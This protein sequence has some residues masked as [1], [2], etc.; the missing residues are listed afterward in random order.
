ML[1]LARTSAS[2]V[3]LEL[4][5]IT[6]DRLLK[7]SAVEV[8]RSPVAHGNRLEPLGDHFTVT[9]DPADGRLHLS[10]DTTTVKRIGEGMAAG[11]L[12][13]E[14]PVGMHAGA[15]MAGGE[16]TLDSSA[17]DW[18]GVEMRGG[19]IAVRGD[20]GDQCGAAY[21]GSRRGVTGG[22]I[23]VRGNVGAECGLLLRRGLIL[24]G[25]GCGPFAGASMIAGTLVAGRLTRGA[26]AGMKRGTLLAAAVEE[27][28]PGFRFACEYRPA[29][30]SLLL[31]ELARHGYDPGPW[32]G[33]PVRL[34][35]GD[36]LTGGRGELL[37]GQPAG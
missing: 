33:R 1:R 36:I 25:G 21:R 13:V 30:L 29:F 9:G 4:D 26:G 10:G 27:L 31:S 23:H 18:L 35:R 6:P 8:A 19:R 16:L 5:G 37:T 12:F 17:G 34:F 28:A 15:R 2:P 7:L 20:A 32:A 14:G 24:V 11:S 3:P 22:V